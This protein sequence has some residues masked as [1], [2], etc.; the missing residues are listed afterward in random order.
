[1]LFVDNI[2]YAIR[3]VIKKELIYKLKKRN[4][5]SRCIKVSWSDNDK[6][7]TENILQVALVLIIKRPENDRSI[8]LASIQKLPACYA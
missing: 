6:G 8:L 4:D 7:T 2:N 5:L 1:M 3:R